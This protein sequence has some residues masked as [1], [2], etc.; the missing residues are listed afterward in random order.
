MCA[1]CKK[2][3][4]LTPKQTE[5]L[6]TCVYSQPNVFSEKLL[7]YVEKSRGKLQLHR[8]SRL[9]NTT[10][11]QFFLFLCLLTVQ[12]LYFCGTLIW[13]LCIWPINY[14]LYLSK[15]LIRLQINSNVE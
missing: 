5:C 9:L 8:V 7:C 2:L 4:G 10:K 11:T 12:T 13:V 3:G 6:Q 1:T 15:E 14:H